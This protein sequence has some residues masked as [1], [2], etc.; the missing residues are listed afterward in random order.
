LRISQSLQYNPPPVILISGGHLVSRE[1]VKALG[2]VEFFEKPFRMDELLGF[3]RGIL[4]L[5]ND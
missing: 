1:T 4:V 2:A 5:P 3:I